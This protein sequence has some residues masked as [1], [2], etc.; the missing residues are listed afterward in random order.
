ALISKRVY[1]CPFPHSKAVKI[2]QEGSG[3]H[4]DPDIVTVFLEKAEDFR[5]IALEH[6]DFEEERQALLL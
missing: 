3:S 1:K 6:A 2:I 4:F 5:K